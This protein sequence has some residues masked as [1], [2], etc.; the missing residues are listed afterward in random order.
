MC[1]ILI[2]NSWCSLVSTS[3]VIHIPSYKIDNGSQTHNTTLQFQKEHQQK[4]DMTKIAAG[5]K[6]VYSNTELQTHSSPHS[7]S[8]SISSRNASCWISTKMAQGMRAQ[9]TH[10]VTIFLWMRKNKIL[11]KM[12]S[13]PTRPNTCLYTSTP[14]LQIHG[15]RPPLKLGLGSEDAAWA[16]CCQQHQTIV[17]GSI[18]GRN[19]GEGVL[20]GG[21]WVRFYL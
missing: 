8:T 20:H 18:L 17:G 7:M 19:P 14:P 11:P 10:S 3:R 4:L 21:C 16:T 5:H 13:C 1:K 12:Y 2:S 15:G 9:F 6:Q